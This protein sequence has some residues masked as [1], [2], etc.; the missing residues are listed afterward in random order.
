[1]SVRRS[2]RARTAPK[3]YGDVE[4][5][6]HSTR[7]TPTVQTVTTI[8]G[9]E[10]YLVDGELLKPREVSDEAEAAAKDNSEELFL[11]TSSRNRVG[12]EG[13]QETIHEI[14]Y[15]KLYR[16]H[17]PNAMILDSNLGKYAEGSFP[18][19]LGRVIPAFTSMPD[20]SDNVV[21]EI[22]EQYMIPAL[23]WI[24][25]GLVKSGHLEEVDGSLSEGA[26][27]EDVRGAAFSFGAGVVV[28]NHEYYYNEK[29]APFEVLNEKEILRKR[30]LGM[31]ADDDSSSEEEV[32]LSAYEKMRAERVARNA[33]R[34]KALGLA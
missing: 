3:N 34:L 17:S 28:P 25:R 6:A 7:T 23:R 24:L 30:R 9:V 29:F 14:F 32:E 11:P 26:V 27:A 10:Y 16:N 19:Y 21:W 18:P 12:V 13:V 22:R 8:A 33:E 2:S 31:V 5:S 1:M 15:A 4:E 20:Y